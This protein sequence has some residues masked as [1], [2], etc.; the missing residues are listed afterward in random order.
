MLFRSFAF[1]AVGV[2]A[3]AGG[4]ATTPWERRENRTVI[5]CLLP[6][7]TA[8]FPSARQV[9]CT[10]WKPRREDPALLLRTPS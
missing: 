1:P 4:A 6:A 7:W 3:L 2:V 8:A 5:S 9:A 10:G